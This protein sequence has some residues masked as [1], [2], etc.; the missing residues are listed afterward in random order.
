MPCI[1]DQTCVQWAIV[2]VDLAVLPC[3]VSF[4]V[5]NKSKRAKGKRTISVGGNINHVER[6]YI[7]IAGIMGC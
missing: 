6:K 4:L 2:H 7:I 1:C 3:C 5:L